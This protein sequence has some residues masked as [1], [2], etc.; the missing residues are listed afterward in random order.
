MEYGTYEEVAMSMGMPQWKIFLGGPV[1]KTFDLLS[2][3]GTF[4]TFCFGQQEGRNRAL[5]MLE[6]LKIVNIRNGC[7]FPA[8]V[9][10]ISA[11]DLAF[12][13]C[14]MNVTSRLSRENPQTN[15]DDS[16]LMI[17][18]LLRQAK[19]CSFNR[20]RFEQYHGLIFTPSPTFSPRHLNPRPLQHFPLQENQTAVL[21]EE[22][23]LLCLE[24]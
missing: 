22:R 10:L 19:F 2:V 15:I 3:L 13:Q 5:K 6:S 1:I 21:V 24:K 4:S 11:V 7:R 12:S 17:G 8:N 16:I 9:D 18:D 23:L 20:E 14:L